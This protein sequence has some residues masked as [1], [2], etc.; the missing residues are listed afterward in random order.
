MNFFNWIREGVRQAVVYGVSDAVGQIG[1]APH[2]ENMGGQLLELLRS[3]P[4]ETARGI[5]VAPGLKRKRLGRSL[6]DIQAATEQ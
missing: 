5:T 3:A 1:E 2:G 6:G 4:E